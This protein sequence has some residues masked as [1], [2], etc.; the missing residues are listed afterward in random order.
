VP[1]YSR[2]Y[3]Y[4]PEQPKRTLGYYLKLSDKLVQ[5]SVQTCRQ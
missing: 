4:S 1:A 3:N 5:Y 2:L